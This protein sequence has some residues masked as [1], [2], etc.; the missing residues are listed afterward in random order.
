M[1]FRKIIGWFLG[2]V[3]AV[4]IIVLITIGSLA[5]SAISEKAA[6]IGTA[7]SIGDTLFRDYIYPLETVALLL[8]SAIV[9]AI[10]LAKRKISE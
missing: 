9:G 2:L 10:V 6:S 5:N 4:Q 3:V 7:Q 8:F 1:N